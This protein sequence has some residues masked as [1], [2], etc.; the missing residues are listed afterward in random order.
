MAFFDEAVNLTLSHEG[1]LT[2]DKYGGLTK[3]GISSNA[4]PNEDIRNMTL[5]RAKAIYE[6]DYWNKL[7][8]DKLD[9]QA[10]ANQ[11]FDIAV[12]SGLNGAKKLLKSTLISLNY[13]MSLSNLNVS[14]T[15]KINN[16]NA[17]AI[18]NKLV[19][20][21]QDF[22]KTL[23]QKDPKENKKFEKG[24][25]NRAVSFLTD[26]TT[27]QAVKTSA[28]FA[29]FFAFSLYIYLKKKG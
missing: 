13:P 23:V 28:V 2:I 4:Y 20:I 19:K 24:W 12:N 11:I 1:G 9:S 6:R 16:L 15:S 26:E 7:N 21:R 17:L 18:N 22:Y 5:D 29:F 25:V 8:L 3:Y 10:L 27:T 14:D